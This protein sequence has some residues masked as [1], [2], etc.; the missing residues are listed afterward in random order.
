MTPDKFVE[1]RHKAVHELMGLNAQCKEEFHLSSWP[2]WDYDL[3]R[4][5]LTF[6][7]NGV[8]K[9]VA[10]IQVVGTTSRSLGTWMWGWANESLPPNAVKDMSS[11]REF[12]HTEAIGELV[13]SELPDDEYLGWGMT[14]VAA[15]LLGARGAYRCPDADGFIYLVYTSIGF[16]KTGSDVSGSYQL[17]EC[18][19]HTNGF[20]TY[21]CEH[22]LANPTQQWFSNEP[23]EAE[24]WPDAWC[25]SCEALFSEQGKWTEKNQ[26]KSGVRMVCHHCYED[27]R[28]QRT[29]PD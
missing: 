27:L 29:K 9:V 14:A 7:E 5:T 6:S 23:D 22:L 19:E 20:A 4:A 15:Q 21:L 1:F 25:A 18:S 10:A 26:A 11:V 13:K 28:S 16:A 24:P 17:A 12:G 2:R 3:E 8:P